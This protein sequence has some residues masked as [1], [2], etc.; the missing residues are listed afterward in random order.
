MGLVSRHLRLLFVITALAVAAFSTGI[1]F[2]FFLVYLAVAIG[3]GSWLYARFGLRGIRADYRVLNPR[4]HVG[5]VLQAIY[6]VENHDRLA[7]PWIECWNDSTLPASLPG[8]VLG[9]PGR[10]R[11][12]WLAKV[13]VTRRGTYRLGPLRVRTGDPFGLFSSEM[14]VGHPT[15]LVVFPEVVAL[16]HWRLPPSPID[17]TTPARRR[18]EAASPLVSSVRPYVHGDAIN[19]IHWLSSA[20]HGELH[21]KEFDLEQAADLWIVLDLERAVHAGVGNDASVETA[22]S[23]AAS[24]ALRTLADN[25]SVA[26]TASARRVQVHQPDRGPRVEQKL[27]HLL[28]N[29]QADGITPLAEVMT[30]TLSQLRRG[31]TVCI[32]TGSTDRTWV[33]A[34]SALRRRG[35][36]A[37][38]IL[39]D[40]ASYIGVDPDD[41]ARAEL[42]AVRHALAE[43][44]IE[45]RLVRR[46]DDIADAIG[47][48]ARA[49]V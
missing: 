17:G 47:G 49:R 14:T 35:V 19:R 44:D 15:S 40:R 1:D 2:L 11:R 13:T 48:R 37:L 8:R 24:V 29:V 41:R 46:G 16:T 45:H 6:R 39:L 5:E 9:L 32:V 21:V 3:V 12:Q 26:M 36:A 28:A 7:K 38:V 25:R 10:G 18:Y 42:A 22:V 31:M 20:R 30:A 23:I 34:L 33:R 43:Y 27:L 4:T